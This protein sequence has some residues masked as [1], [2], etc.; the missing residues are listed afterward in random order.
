M[1]HAEPEQGADNATLNMVG[2]AIIFNDGLKY[3]N[4]W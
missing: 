4:T 3:F 2:Q 1:T